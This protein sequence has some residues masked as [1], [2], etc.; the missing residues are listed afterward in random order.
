M[1]KSL[2]EKVLQFYATKSI[3]IKSGLLF[4]AAIIVTLFVSGLFVNNDIDS[5]A[6]DF[7][8]VETGIDLEKVEENLKK[9][10]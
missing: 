7:I 8:K 2:I 4:L 3:L 6:D 1:V 10:T 5:L 9:G